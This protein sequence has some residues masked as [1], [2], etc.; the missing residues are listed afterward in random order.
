MT[1]RMKR[2]L[3]AAGILI[4]A[5]VVVIV[6]VRRNRA[7]GGGNGDRTGADGKPLPTR[8]Q[9]GVA[10]EPAAGFTG[11]RLDLED[12]PAG[13]ER[14]EGQVIDEREQ[15]V[16][17]ARVMLDSLPPREAITEADGG[18]FFDALIARTYLLEARHGDDAA[19]PVICRLSPAS[20]P[21]VLR[22]RQA[23]RVEV[24]VVDAAD[25][26]LA[27]ALV[28]LR[29]VGSVQET[30]DAAGLAVLRGLNA[31]T[32]V[33]KIAAAGH[34][35]VWDLIAVSGAPGEVVR[36]TVQLREGV[37]VSGTVV[38]PAGRPVEG[39]RVL[40]EQV[41]SVWDVADPRLDSVITDARGRW[42]IT[43]LGRQTYRF[44][45]THPELAPGFS[46][47]VPLADGSSRDDLVIRLELGGRLA[48][49]VLGANGTPAAGARVQAASYDPRGARVRRAHSDADGRFEIGGLPRGQVQVLAAGDEATSAMV[50]F[51]LSQKPERTDVELQ[52]AL[53]G[54]IVGRVLTSTGEEVAEARV[55]ASPFA[56]DTF[57]ESM[58][59]R[60]RGPSSD[61]ADAG[62]RFQLRGL[63]PGKYRVRAIRPGSSVELLGMNQGVTVD[64]GTTDVKVVVDDLTTMS[65]TVRFREGGT[66]KLFQVR[67]GRSGARSFAGTDGKFTLTEVP[68]GKQFVTISGP[69]IVMVHRDDVTLTAGKD[70]DVGTIEV[71]R[72][73]TIRGRV[74]SGGAGVG[75]ALVV[76]GPDMLA[77][78]FSLM[79]FKDR[80][81]RLGDKQDVTAADGTYTITGVGPAE[82]V[83]VAERDNV[84]RS[85]AVEIGKGTTDMTIDL[86]VLPFGSATGHLRVNGTPA[87]GVVFMRPANA[88]NMNFLVTTGSDGSFHFDRLAPGT[89][90]GFGILEKESAGGAEGGSGD[91]VVVRPGE[92]TRVDFDIRKGDLAVTLR[93]T[94]AG[95]AVQYGYG[96]LA[97]FPNGNPSRLPTTIGEARRFLTEIT[98]GE[99]YEGFIVTDR[100]KTF[101]GL[102]AGEYGACIS[103]LTG[104][105]DDP[106]VIA[107]MQADVVNTPIYC[108]PFKVAA[109]PK[110]QSVTI[111]VQPV[112]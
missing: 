76:I 29:N 17:G 99:I 91:S 103:P 41:T 45:A 54:V 40:G 74:T 72:G 110:Q 4:A 37:A 7:D 66:P 82:L 25:K 84:G 108:K 6:M 68:A 21:I 53:T 36:R 12:D 57:G 86:P 93:M 111:E 1:P 32:H 11:E 14:L 23:S 63:A 28:E 38:D 104:P 48:G 49:R 42:Q 102:A 31:G 79:P 71:V 90:M 69:E 51:D 89:Y 75:G 94:S 83:L 27:G 9:R 26:P 10:A 24:T 35:S 65:G 80:A 33:L 64:S 95:D 87:A 106:D 44:R 98:G 15:P 52:L 62:G 105:P 92:T 73:R 19:G 50:A 107:R 96:V 100:Q 59:Q 46:E 39:A 3:L 16:A 47:P 67:L 34:A 20:E 13:N 2:I 43:G 8:S 77:D 97:R 101:S 78:G 60:L 85:A 109:E 30:S 55:I 56:D 22:L 61:V 58:E 88:P 5:L 81:I 112:R 70:N 18:F